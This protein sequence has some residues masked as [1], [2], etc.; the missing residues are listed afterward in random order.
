M[1]DPFGRGRSSVISDIEIIS[2]KS[3][4]FTAFWLVDEVS[5]GHVCTRNIILIE[6]LSSFLRYNYFT[7]I[8]EKGP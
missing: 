1:M 7:T 8:I 2:V 3:L 5:N 6:R 4:K